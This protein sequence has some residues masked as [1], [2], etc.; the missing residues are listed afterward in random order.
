MS[1]LRAVY[2]LD[3]VLLQYFFSYFSLSKTLDLSYKT[4]FDL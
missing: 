3:E 2:V 4:D 1:M